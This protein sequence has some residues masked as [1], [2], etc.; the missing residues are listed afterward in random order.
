MTMK[1]MEGK[2]TKRQQWN[3]YKR[4]E[5]QDKV[6]FDTV[7]CEICNRMIYMDK[8]YHGSYVIGCPACWAEV[9]PLAPP[10]EAG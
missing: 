7:Q 5:R 1:Q 2:P 6:G 4:S 9:V 3:A 8:R 10:G